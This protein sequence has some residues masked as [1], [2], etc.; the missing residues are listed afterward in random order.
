MTPSWRA[1]VLA[2]GQ[3]RGER[4]P[5]LSAF[6]PRPRWNLR[7]SAP[8]TGPPHGHRYTEQPPGTEGREVRAGQREQTWADE[9]I[10]SKELDPVS[11]PQGQQLTAPA[12][13]SGRPSPRT[14]PGSPAR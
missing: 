9:R 7:A 14:R 13:R 12:P 11:P 1:R 4:E 2:G 5:G 6:S 10:V 8:V 3:T